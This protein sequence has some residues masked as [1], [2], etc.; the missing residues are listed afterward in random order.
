MSNRVIEGK[1]VSIGYN[2]FALYIKN[3]NKI[4]YVH[5][6]PPIVG[7]ETIPDLFSS[8]DLSLFESDAKLKKETL[9]NFWANTSLYQANGDWK[10]GEW[11]SN[12][13]PT[14]DKTWCTDIFIGDSVKLELIKYGI[15]PYKTRMSKSFEKTDAIIPS[16]DTSAWSCNVT[17]LTNSDIIK[18]EKID[19]AKTYSCYVCDK[20]MEQKAIDVLFVWKNLQGNRYVKILRRGNSNPNVD[21]PGLQMPGAGE[22]R[23][24]G[25][26]I[27]FK[28][29]VLRAVNE[30][31]G[32]EYNTLTECYLLNIGEFNNDKR[33]PRYWSFSAEQDGQIIEFG[34]KRKS[35]TNVY[36]LYLESDSNDKPS[37]SEPSDMIEINSKRWVNL[38]SPILSNKEIWLVPEHSIYFSFAVSLLNRFDELPIE[39]K[40][41]KKIYI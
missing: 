36:V 28:S 21:M 31:I 35:S 19:E 18:E 37:E 32:I 1:V 33:D 15:I 23:E 17:I 22:H 7:S 16:S 26:V 13:L 11:G 9:V 40:I 27:N 4:I 24:P 29:E 34:I 14:T 3:Y 30:E 25:P 5:K 8:S 2:V 39:C 41:S 10:G 12:N 38:N 20:P 6:F